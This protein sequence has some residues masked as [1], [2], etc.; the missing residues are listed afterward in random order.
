MRG[1]HG[2]MG[3]KTKGRGAQMKRKPI[4]RHQ[5]LEVYR[6]AFQAAMRI[7]ELTKHFPVE[8]R[9][10]LTDQIRRASRSMACSQEPMNLPPCP[11]AP[12]PAFSACLLRSCPVYLN[13]SWC[14]FRKIDY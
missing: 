8:E 9:F 13:V 7:F 3:E 2:G 11:R 10:S 14:I 1:R 6:V 4:T 5:E 12:M